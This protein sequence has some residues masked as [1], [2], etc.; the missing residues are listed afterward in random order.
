M[1]SAG[2]REW[3]ERPRNNQTSFNCQGLS[4][5]RSRLLRC[6]G[7]RAP[8]PG[9][10]AERGQSRSSG[11][12]WRALSWRVHRPRRLPLVT[13]RARLQNP[14]IVALRATPSARPALPSPGTPARS[15]PDLALLRLAESAARLMPGFHPRA[16]A[17]PPQLLG[18]SAAR[19]L[20]A[21]MLA[22]VPRTLRGQEPPLH[23][24]PPM[25]PGNWSSALPVF[26]GFQFSHA[27]PP[28][29]P[30]SDPVGTARRTGATLPEPRPLRQRLVR[31]SV[32]PRHASQF[33]PSPA[34]IGQDLA[35]GGTA[36][37]P[38]G[39]RAS[40]SSRRGCGG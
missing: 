12:T 18:K 29:F 24:A 9:V 10:G 22:S 20:Q 4:S 3:R 33:A 13:V 11:C 25:P 37:A 19:L 21:P 26:C 40:G 27:S 36:W 35:N 17:P 38:P 32:R 30:A 16:S 39:P 6:A 8:A 14:I 15:S 31:Q 34:L 23:V 7:T 28:G 1:S 5:R 2:G